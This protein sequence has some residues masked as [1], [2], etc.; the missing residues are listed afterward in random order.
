MRQISFMN[1]VTGERV[2]VIIPNEFMSD[3]K[4]INDLVV[5]VDFNS[6]TLV[7]SKESKDKNKLFYL[8]QEF[9]NEMFE[10]LYYL[11]YGEKGRSTDYELNVNKFNRL[12]KECFIGKYEIFNKINDP[13]LYSTLFTSFMLFSDKLSRFRKDADEYL[14]SMTDI[15][16]YV[17]IFSRIIALMRRIENRDTSVSKDITKLST[18][19]SA[20]ANYEN[21]YGDYRCGVYEILNP[22]LTEVNNI[23][24]NIESFPK[25]KDTEDKIKRV[26]EFF[27]LVMDTLIDYSNAVK[28]IESIVKDSSCRNDN[29]KYQKSI[30]YSRSVLNKIHKRFLALKLHT[31]KEPHMSEL[32]DSL[33]YWYILL[34]NTYDN[35][36]RITLMKSGASEICELFVKSDN[37]SHIWNEQNIIAMIYKYIKNKEAWAGISKQYIKSYIFYSVMLARYSKKTISEEELSIQLSKTFDK[38]FNTKES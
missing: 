4:D 35:V 33:S 2:K 37:F 8:T 22:Y 11:Y 29:E 28:K 38:L 24:N 7:E 17:D 25:T 30:V 10:K 19:F 36:Y 12:L 3:V 15:N 27:A 9:A 18:M 6:Y 34:L 5:H 14:N 21:E 16:V 13:M 32:V 1:R 20:Y 31:Y 23:F 26:K